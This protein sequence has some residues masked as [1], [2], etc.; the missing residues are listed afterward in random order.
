MAAPTPRLT[1]A[2]AAITAALR[3]TIPGVERHYAPT[4]VVRDAPWERAAWDNGS[5]VLYFVWPGWII[6]ERQQTQTETD[7]ALITVLAGRN[8][9][10]A[11]PT[12][13]SGASEGNEPWAIKDKLSA[14]V[15]NQLDGALASAVIPG[16]V[17]HDLRYHVNLEPARVNGWDVVQVLV[18]ASWRRDRGGA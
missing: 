7:A 5:A 9:T 10:L 14:D 6:G 8:A 15:R 1:Q 13:S 12:E 11:R 3:V 2:V 18:D 16:A 4:T 17:I